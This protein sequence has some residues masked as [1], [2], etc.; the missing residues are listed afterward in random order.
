MTG[1]IGILV[2]CVRRG[3]LSGE[4]AEGLLAEMIALGYYSPFDSLDQ[5]AD[6]QVQ[7]A[8]EDEAES[9]GTAPDRACS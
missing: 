8:G 3:Y 5:I 1:T 7:K 9:G 4:Q 2:L 6:P